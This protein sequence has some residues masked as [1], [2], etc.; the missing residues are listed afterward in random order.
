MGFQA[1]GVWGFEL[2][3]RMR[4]AQRLRVLLSGSEDK[5]KAQRVP[6]TVMGDNFPNHDSSSFSRNPTV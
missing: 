1:L 2:R 5:V 3:R 6:G 4:R